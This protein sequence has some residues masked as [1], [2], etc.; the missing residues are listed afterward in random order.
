L[1]SWYNYTVFTCI[2]H[3]KTNI[4]A[5]AYTSFI[6]LQ[7]LTT[8]NDDPAPAE[9]TE[10]VDLNGTS[11]TIQSKIPQIDTTGI[12]MQTRNYTCGPAALTTV[13][14]NMGINATEQ[15]LMI[16]AGTNNKSGTSI[17]GLSQAAQS[18][19]LSAAG[20]ELSI[21]EL[22]KNHIVHVVLNGTPHYSVVRRV[23]NESV[24]LADPSKG[25]IVLSREEFIAIFTGNVLVIS[26]PNM[27]VIVMCIYFFT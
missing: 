22:K 23:T 20:I 9:A 14:Q 24:Y 5:N 16:L 13:L 8:A 27:Q 15:K 25:N 18:K 21:H 1:F 19:G 11:E 6:I 17:H 10:T 7:I 3:C 26:D 12:V 2:L 4:A